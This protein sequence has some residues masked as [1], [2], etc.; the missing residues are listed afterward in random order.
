M[1]PPS[2]LTPFP[3]PA[4]GR[5]CPE[6][7]DEGYPSPKGTK[8]HLSIILPAKNE[9]AGLRQTLPSLRALFPQAEIIVVDDGSTDETAAVATE[10]GAQEIGRE[11]CRERVCKYVSVWVVAEPLKK[12]K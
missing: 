8:M 7:A 12:K 5:R 1:P 3:S 10:H 4:R 9:A 2:H 6:G 11:S